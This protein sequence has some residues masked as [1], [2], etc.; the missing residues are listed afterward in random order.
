[1]AFHYN[2]TIVRDGL[3]LL[4]DAANPKSYPGSGTT[5][6]DLS[7]N[8]LDMTMVG[9]V[10]WNAAGYF[11]GWSA[12]NYFQQNG[13]WSSYIPTASFPRTLIAVVERG[14][15]GT[16]YEHAIHYGTATTD[17]SY[18]LTINVA[19]S[20]LSDH[21]WADANMPDMTLSINTKAVASVKFPNSSNK[22]RFFING[23]HGDSTILSTGLPVTGTATFRIGSR[24]STAQENWTGK[25]YAVAI[26][27]R[28][29][30]DAEVNEVYHAFKGRINL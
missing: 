6:Y 7:G 21:L 8:G 23:T 28:V 19:S 26:Y 14:S 3:V 5:W 13:S 10:T 11:S 24:I 1:M 27:N 29:L 9:T 15:A 12:A 4:L 30:S 2:T 17:Q 18:G 16:S 22:S 20:K 25:I